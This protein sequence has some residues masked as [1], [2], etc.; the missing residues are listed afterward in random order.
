MIYPRT[1]NWPAFWRFLLLSGL[2]FGSF[3]GL[4][5]V[6]MVSTGRAEISEFDLL[7]AAAFAFFFARMVGRSKSALGRR[8]IAGAVLLG[9]PLVVLAAAAGSAAWEA[10]LRLIRG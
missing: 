4:R 9:P 7:G 10:W 5:F 3:V 6:T 2:F 8:I 1:T